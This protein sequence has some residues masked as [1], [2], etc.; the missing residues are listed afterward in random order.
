MTNRYAGCEHLYCGTLVRD[1]EVMVVLVIA[2]GDK[3]S[4]PKR[5]LHQHC[6]SRGKTSGLAFRFKGAVM[7]RLSSWKDFAPCFTFCAVG[8]LQDL[9]EAAYKQASPEMEARITEH[10]RRY[11][12]RG[13][14]V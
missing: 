11:G 6:A 3:K 1:K 9:V 4:Q 7:S 8:Q 10:R 12:H 13:W 14:R 5:R 2:G